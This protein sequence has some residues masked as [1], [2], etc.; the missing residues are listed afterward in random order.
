[1][2]ASEPAL[3]GP[4]SPAA[5]PGQGGSDLEPVSAGQL[6]AAARDGAPLEGELMVGA[7]VLPPA[8][9]E[10]AT[11]LTLLQALRRRWLHALPVGLLLAGLVGGLVWTLRPDKY[12]AF[13]LLQIAPVEQKLLQDSNNARPEVDR[14]GQYQKTQV[15]LITS[16]PVIR[17]ALKQEKVR[18]LPLIRQQD[19]AAEWLEKQL[20][21]EIVENTELIKLSLSSRRHEADLEPIVN[22]IQ[23]AYMNEIVKGEHSR[24]MALLND[25]EKIYVSSQEKLRAQRESLRRLADTLKTGDS[26]ILTIKQKNLLEEYAALK[27]ELAGLHAR[28]RDAQVKLAA[29]QLEPDGGSGAV[30]AGGD[31]ASA[32]PGRSG[33]DTVVGREVDADPV[34]QKQQAEV[35]KLVEQIAQIERLAVNPDHPLRTERKRQLDAAR[36]VLEKM[37]ADRWQAVAERVR[38]GQKAERLLH[39]LETTEEMKILDKQRAALQ[40]E[41][42]NVSREVDRIGVSSIELELKRNEIDQAELVLKA[43]RNEKER[44]QVELQS[45]AK[46][47]ISVLAPADEATVLSKKAHLLETAAGAFGGLFLGLFAVSYREFRA[48]RLY[49]TAEVTQGLR[50][51]VMGTLPALPARRLALGA[52]AAGT[53]RS[54]WSAILTESIDSVRTMLL[55]GRPAGGSSV[56][57]ITSACSGEGKTTL[58][59]HLAASLARAGRR[60]LLV[61]CDL[62]SP[63]LHR[64]FDVPRAPGMCEVLTGTA[65]AEGTVYATPVDRL[66]LL[67]AG[68][69]SPEAATALAQG[70]LRAVLER[71]RDHFDFLVVDS[72]PV[73]AVPDALMIGDGADGVAFSIRPGVSQA[74]QVYAAY[75]RLRELGLPF[76]GTVVNGITDKA[77]YAHNYRYV[78][79]TAN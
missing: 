12:T 77:L 27:K 61:D 45:T 18:R 72:S 2:S 51:R 37:R 35:Y 39:S 54:A 76:V 52:P 36:A 29:Q 43:L 34:I 70:T 25:M 38:Q 21:A 56:L 7:N 20:S 49:T 57:M 53:S 50:L 65:A 41:L 60:T 58:A 64:L 13:A 47:R 63:S 28:L 40:A 79:N 9:T 22:A 10:T 31:W 73:L 68:Q 4:K 11:P 8:L 24:Q 19:D 75:E 3:P 17:A 30:Q 6:V 48:R 14:N 16:R 15:A 32:A 67:P 59:S 74:P 62:R 26:Q 55:Q 71:L 33:L 44:L 23:E 5:Q 42:A 69:F 1:M 46:R 78:V 66:H